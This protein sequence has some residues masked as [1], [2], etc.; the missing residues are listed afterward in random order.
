MDRHGP[1]Q[2][3]QTKVNQNGPKQFQ[4]DQNKLNGLKWTK[5]DQIKKKI[6]KKN[7]P[8]TRFA[9]LY[10]FDIENEVKNVINYVS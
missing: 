8:Y 10:T 6:F 1:K 3:K 5:V 9:P 2:I 7:P 4:R